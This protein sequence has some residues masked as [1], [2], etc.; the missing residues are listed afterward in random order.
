[1]LGRNATPESPEIHDYELR[2]SRRQF[3][4]PL[5]VFETR[6]NDLSGQEKV[7]RLR[8]QSSDVYRVTDE[9]HS[10]VSD[11]T[12]SS[13]PRLFEGHSPTLSSISLD[14]E[15]PDVP[16]AEQIEEALEHSVQQK[17]TAMETCEYIKDKYP[18]FQNTD[19]GLQSYIR[20]HRKNDGISNLKRSKW[21]LVE[22]SDDDKEKDVK[23]APPLPR[24][25][26]RS[27]R[28]NFCGDH[29]PSDDDDY[30]GVTHK[31]RKVVQPSTFN[32]GTDFPESEI[33]AKVHGPEK[34]LKP[35]NQPTKRPIAIKIDHKNDEKK[36]INSNEHILRLHNKPKPAPAIRK[37]QAT[38]TGPIRS[39]KSQAH[40]HSHPKYSP[41]VKDVPPL[42]N[43]Y[44]PHPGYFYYSPRSLEIIRDASLPFP[45]LRHA[46]VKSDPTLR[47]YMRHCGKLDVGHVKFFTADSN[48][49]KSE[50]VPV[51]GSFLTEWGR[52]GRFNETWE[53]LE[54]VEEWEYN[55]SLMHDI[56][57]LNDGYK[58]IMEIDAS[59][60]F[61]HTDQCEAGSVAHTVDDFDELKLLDMVDSS[62]E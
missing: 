52:L 51:D 4:R 31:K 12:N 38:S 22:D 7:G 49:E 62:M 24:L 39:Q 5:P 36:E 1:M 29:C 53:S 61:G 13:I 23:P 14:N 45:S 33:P 20:S 59:A 18:H 60:W 48:G 46:L 27:V 54:D 6:L 41:H 56:Y 42:R 50:P 21:T 35:A 57:P 40:S 55:A 9:D 30:Q 26:T 11:M 43:V 2:R 47:N 34:K 15:R 10:G 58:G 19:E 44:D 3:S 16:L 17:M 32:S 28:I 37:H 8:M 25:R